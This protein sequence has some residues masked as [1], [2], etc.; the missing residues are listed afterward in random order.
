MDTEHNA[1]YN[2]EEEL[3][4]YELVCVW[5]TIFISLTTIY[6]YFSCRL[7]RSESTIVSQVRARAGHRG[8]IDQAARQLKEPAQ[9]QNPSHLENQTTPKKRISA[10]SSASIGAGRQAAIARFEEQQKAAVE[11]GR[12]AA[13]ERKEKRVEAARDVQRERDREE[14]AKRDARAKELAQAREKSAGLMS[15]L[16]RRKL[17][18]LAQRE[19]QAQDNTSRRKEALQETRQG[20]KRQLGENL[21][22]VQVYAKKAEGSDARALLTSI[23]RSSL[24]CD[25]KREV[26]KELEVPV[27]EQVLVVNGQLLKNDTSA[28]VEFVH[29]SV[30]EICIIVLRHG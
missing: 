6:V 4:Y 5:A 18:S 22:Q 20:I 16:Q 14:E 24:I 10:T 30:S 26:E 12:I 17:D 28:L 29:N 3:N 21:G 8:A 27:D 15:E 19:A 2:E 1:E 7:S 9:P 11:A 13:E 25:I 23:D